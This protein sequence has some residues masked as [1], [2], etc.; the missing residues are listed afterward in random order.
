MKRAATIAIAD[1]GLM[2][3]FTLQN[4]CPFALQSEMCSTCVQLMNMFISP[5]STRFPIAVSFF[6]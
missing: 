5:N 4:P 1:G 2:T 6:R 3:N